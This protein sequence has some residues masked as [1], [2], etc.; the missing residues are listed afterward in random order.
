MDVEPNR[1]IVCDLECFGRPTRLRWRCRELL[2]SARTLTE[3]LE[4]L[5]AQVVLGAARIGGYPVPGEAEGWASDPFGRFPQRYFKA[6]EW[7]GHVARDGATF[8]D[9]ASYPAP[10]AVPPSLPQ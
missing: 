4:F 6:G 7:T 8:P 10:S 3:P 2:C 9:P 1:R 5:D